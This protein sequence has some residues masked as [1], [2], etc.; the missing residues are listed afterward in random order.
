M[1]RKKVISPFTIPHLLDASKSMSLL[2]QMGSASTS[3]SSSISSETNVAVASRRPIPVGARRQSALLME[4]L[5]RDVE[6]SNPNK[7]SSTKEDSEPY[8]RVSD[9]LGMVDGGSALGLARRNGSMT[10]SN[11]SGR[12]RSRR[13]SGQAGGSG[14]LPQTYTTGYKNGNPSRRDSMAMFADMMLND[15][16]FDIDAQRRF[17]LANGLDL[18]N[19][20][21]SLPG[22][23]RSSG[24]SFSFSGGSSSSSSNS[25]S[26]NYALSGSKRKGTSIKD[27]QPKVKKVK[28][29]RASN[30]SFE[31]RRR[32]R[33]NNAMNQLKKICLRATK[34]K[35]ATKIEVL[36]MAIGMLAKVRAESCMDF[37]AQYDAADASVGGELQEKA[38]NS[39]TN[40]VRRSIRERKRRIKVNILEHELS[41]LALA[42]TDNTTK[43]SASK[44]QILEHAC[45]ALGDPVAPMSDEEEEE[46]GN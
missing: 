32:T 3:S 40:D 38:E 18:D 23:A 2:N 19:L 33:V 45:L 12:R 37:Q 42:G 6:G 1:E 9:L 44:C 34:T 43:S 10:L 26:N 35:S 36:E 13:L 16:S 20:L 30:R 14:L 7:R 22:S 39:G 5:T 27:R 8:Q 28:Q 24:S 29:Q 11:S 31:A 25:N 41:R 4:Q 15:T 46:G 17:S 21:M